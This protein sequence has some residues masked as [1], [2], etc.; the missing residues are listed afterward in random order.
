MLQTH[1]HR[2]H[3]HTL[4]HDL[5]SSRSSSPLSLGSFDYQPP[6][7]GVMRQRRLTTLLELRRTYHDL[8]HANQ[9]LQEPSPI[10]DPSSVQR[11]LQEEEEGEEPGGSQATS[12]ADSSGGLDSAA[13]TSSTSSIGG[14][15]AVSLASYTEADK[16]REMLEQEL[17]EGALQ[18]VADMLLT[19][20]QLKASL[21]SLPPGFGEVFEPELQGPGEELVRRT[22]LELSAR[23]KERVEQEL[24]LLPFGGAQQAQALVD[25]RNARYARSRLQVS[26]LTGSGGSG[27]A[28][29][30]GGAGGAAEGGSPS[31]IERLELAEKVAEQ[32]V[33]RRIKPALR[34]AQEQELG[35][36][37]KGSGAYLKVWQMDGL[38][39]GAKTEG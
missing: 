3:T 13:A 35:D 38:L 30:A 1:P 16:E 37:L 36:L 15:S 23:L 34:R 26:M 14:A 22:T 33:E 8:L 18:T 25:A 9:C 24:P 11:L 10:Y 32:F 6:V 31:A 17:Q 39:Q 27:A 4:T 2:P 28:A 5:I 19:A 29:A 7:K 21:R 12:G 20:E